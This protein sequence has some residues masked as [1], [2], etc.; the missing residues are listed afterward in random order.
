MGPDTE[1]IAGYEVYT[2]Q[3]A[4]FYKSN[5]VF[6]TVQSTHP[7]GTPLHDCTLSNADFV[8]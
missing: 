6:T 8:D 4:A 7:L 3:A 2:P 1:I 5:A